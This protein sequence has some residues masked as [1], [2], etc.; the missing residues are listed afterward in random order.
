MTTICQ[1]TITTKATE[2]SRLPLK[3]L[4]LNDKETIPHMHNYVAKLQYTDKDNIFHDFFCRNLT[5]EPQ[6]LPVLKKY[7]HIEENQQERCMY[8]RT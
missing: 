5:P 2:W 1:I 7:K 3:H 4:V 8:R 6:K